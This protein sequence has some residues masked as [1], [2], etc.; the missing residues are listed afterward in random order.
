MDA[1]WAGFLDVFPS[2]SGPREFSPHTRP[3]QIWH[4]V[5]PVILP[6][7]DDHKPAKTRK[8][9]ERALIDS[10]IVNPCEYEWGAVSRFRKS[11]SAHKHDRH[12]RPTG[13]LR[14]DYLLSQTVVHL[15]PRFSDAEVSGPI[16]IGAGRHYGFG[17]MLQVSSM[18]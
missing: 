11:Y 4:S 1:A 5:T 15:T 6:G 14:P 9:I 17:L 3:S 16:V 7:H 18:V 12:K 10:G 13:Y 8:P 2:A